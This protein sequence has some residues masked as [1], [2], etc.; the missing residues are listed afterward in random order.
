MRDERTALT[1]AADLVVARWSLF[2]RQPTAHAR[3][4]VPVGARRPPAAAI[5]ASG[6]KVAKELESDGTE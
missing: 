6:C 2:D 3:G 1:V 4:V 5:A